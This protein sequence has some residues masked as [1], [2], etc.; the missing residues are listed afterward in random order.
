MNIV[1]MGVTGSGKTTVGAALARTLGWRF[2]D[3]DDFHPEAN[4]RKMASGIPLTDDDRWPWLDR[5]RDEM[6]S[7]R[8][9]GVDVVLACSAL[10]ASY[11]ARLAEAGEVRYVYLEGTRE[12]IAERLASRR[13]RYM[14]PSLLASQ[15]ETL[16]PPTDAVQV[17][18][19]LAPE[20][21]V[22]SILARLGLTARHRSAGAQG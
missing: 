5:L 14:P 4:V 22:A 21:Q 15:F 10:K 12:S 3:A 6:R 1:V 8:A 16:E 7:A 17:D 11:R 2:L 13:H 20:E 18:L 19:R 9:S